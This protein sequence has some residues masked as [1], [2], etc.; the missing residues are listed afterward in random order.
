MKALDSF[1]A[2]GTGMFHAG[3]EFEVEDHKG[4]EFEKAGLAVA[5][6]PKPDE[7]DAEPVSP[8]EP[9]PEDE[10]AEPEELP[11]PVEPEPAA[12]ADPPPKNKAAAR[13]K[14]KAGA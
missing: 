4:R 7:P 1:H 11:E 6:G 5:T 12:K 14:T 2:S 3:D 10:P 8:P 13:A 9:G